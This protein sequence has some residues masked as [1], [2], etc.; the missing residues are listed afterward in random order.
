MDRPEPVLAYALSSSDSSVGIFPV[1]ATILL[2]WPDIDDDE[3]RERVR[4]ILVEAFN[5]LFDGLD[6][7]WFHDEC[8]DC[9]GRDGNHKER[10][11]SKREAADA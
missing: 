11:P 4:S 8:P 2:D 5:E 10:C 6:D 1:E 3:E 9:H 7:V